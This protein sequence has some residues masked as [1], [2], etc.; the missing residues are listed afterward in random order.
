MVL[1]YVLSVI[2]MQYVIAYREIRYL[3]NKKLYTVVCAL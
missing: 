3:V 2:M 1:L